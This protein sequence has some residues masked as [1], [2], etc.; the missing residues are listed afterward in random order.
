[1]KTQHFIFLSG[2]HNTVSRAT[3]CPRAKGWTIMI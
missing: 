3:C 1:M 2:K